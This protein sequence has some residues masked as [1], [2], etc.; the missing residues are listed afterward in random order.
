MLPNQPKKQR[1][2]TAKSIHEFYEK[3]EALPT[4]PVGDGRCQ[5]VRKKVGQRILPF[6]EGT[7]PDGKTCIRRLSV[8]G[9]TI[10]V[11]CVC[12]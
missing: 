9:D 11:E 3:A 12:Q 5:L 6:C 1:K 7:C 8:T 2:I 10:T 4:K